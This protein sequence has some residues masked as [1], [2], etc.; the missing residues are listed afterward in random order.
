MDT[1]ETN[2]RPL[3]LRT[4]AAWLPI[5]MSLASLLLVVVHVATHGIGREADEGTA[6]H[7][8]QLLMAGQML[9]VLYFAVRWLPRAPKQA[10]LVLVLQATTAFAALAVLFWM[11]HAG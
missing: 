2:S 8:Y 9:I 6:A 7:L 11:E 3:L 5:V 1:S 10:M 4:P